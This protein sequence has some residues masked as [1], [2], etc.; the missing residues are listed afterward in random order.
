MLALAQYFSIINSP[1]NFYGND[2]AYYCYCIILFPYYGLSLFVSTFTVTVV[3][4][5]VGL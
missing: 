1:F 3:R 4:V 5:V 2:P